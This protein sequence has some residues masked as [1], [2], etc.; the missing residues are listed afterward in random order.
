[1]NI[2]FRLFGA[3]IFGFQVSNV[4]HDHFMIFMSGNDRY[5][6]ILQCRCYCLYHQQSLCYG[7]KRTLWLTIQF[8]L[9]LP[10]HGLRKGPGAISSHIFSKYPCMLLKRVASTVAGILPWACGTRHSGVRRQKNIIWKQFNNKSLHGTVSPV[11]KLRFIP[12]LYWCYMWRLKSLPN[13]R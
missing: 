12:A 2:I 3:K 4:L 6:S 10:I 8:I 11:T 1:M 5:W 9:S 13:F 7:N